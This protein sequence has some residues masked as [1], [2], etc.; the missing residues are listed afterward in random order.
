LEGVAL[1]ILFEE[2]WGMNVVS[3]F[4]GVI[5]FGIPFPFHKVLEHSR[6]PM[7]SVVDQMFYFIFLRPLDKV[8]WGPGEVGAV[9]GV[10]LVW[11]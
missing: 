4:P 1:V 2:S 5:A 9:D 11:D 8:R 7:M 6:L 3:W 10:F